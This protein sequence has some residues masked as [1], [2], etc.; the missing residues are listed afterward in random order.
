MPLLCTRRNL[1]VP[2]GA[3][4]PS[5][6]GPA[7][8]AFSQGKKISALLCD[9]NSA[10]T[11]QLPAGKPRAESGK[12][13][14][15]PERCLLLGGTQRGDGDLLGHQ[16]VRSVRSGGRSYHPE[17]AGPGAAGS[18]VGESG[19]TGGRA[20]VGSARPN[21]LSITCHLT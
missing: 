20:V 4:A 12:G 1:Q 17:G 19:Q 18:Q 2:R 11:E 13:Y 5:V 15:A 10:S 8:P 21:H 16:R 6:P 14:R 7:E 9:G 3:A